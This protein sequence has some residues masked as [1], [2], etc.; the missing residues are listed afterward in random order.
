MVRGLDGAALDGAAPPELQQLLEFFEELG[1]TEP[2]PVAEAVRRQGRYVLEQARHFEEPRVRETVERAFR[3]T[4]LHREKLG[5]VLLERTNWRLD[6]LPLCHKQDLRRHFPRG[7]VTDDVEL[8]ALLEQGEIVIASTSGTTGERLQVYSDTRI[9]RLPPDFARFWNLHGLPT[10][11]P[12]RTAVFTSPTCSGATC[13]RGF[14][15]FEDRIVFENT[16]FL[17]SP[18]NPFEMTREQARRAAEDMRRFDAD[19]WVVNPVYLAVLAERAAAWGYELPSPRAIIV[20]FQFFSHCQKRVFAKHFD[21]PVFQFYTATDLGGSQIGVSCPEGVL[22]VRLDQVFVELLREGVP[23]RDGEIGQVT[24]TTHHAFMPLV[25]YVLGDLAR[26]RVAPCR[27]DVGSAWPGL[28]VE[29]RMQDAFVREHGLISTLEVDES[30]REFPFDLYQLIEVSKGEFRLDV[31]E[32]TGANDWMGSAREVLAKLLRTDGIAVNRV[33][34]LE[35]DR[36]QKFRFT[37]PYVERSA[38]AAH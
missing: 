15:D 32:A 4:A 34:R 6:E 2:T 1:M 25:R 14:K 8:G 16:L 27:C 30:L 37:V 19:L 33:R 10:D 38:R 36:S 13:T 12:V 7:L 9:P 28:V 11:R 22:H 35:L 29:G 31:I 5:P 26:F 3:S 17:D 23:V 21:T 24:V 20:T 18:T